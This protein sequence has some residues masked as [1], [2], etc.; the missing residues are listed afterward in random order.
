MDEMDELTCSFRVCWDEYALGADFDFGTLSSEQKQMLAV[1]YREHLAYY[2]RKHTVEEVETFLSEYVRFD[3]FSHNP[4]N[5]GFLIEDS[6]LYFETQE[7][8]DRYCRENW[9]IT[10]LQAYQENLAFYTEWR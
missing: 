10:Y 8:I 7:A 2:D 5:C 3:S 1:L 9:A 4:M 6:G